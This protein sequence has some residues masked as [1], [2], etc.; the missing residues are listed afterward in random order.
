[1]S[2]AI[3]DADEIRNEKPPVDIE[4]ELAIIANKIAAE[5]NRKGTF[6]QICVRELS[7][8]A[9]KFLVEEKHYKVF[10]DPVDMR[11]NSSDGW[12]IDWSPRPA[13]GIS[14]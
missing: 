3:P 9:R 11:D 7:E 13:G 5:R 10:L 14:K 2:R 1:M 8:E 4:A 12:V 6:K